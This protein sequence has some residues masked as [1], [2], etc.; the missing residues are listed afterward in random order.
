M[1]VASRSAIHCVGHEG[2]GVGDHQRHAAPER[3]ADGIAGFRVIGGKLPDQQRSLFAIKTVKALG[4]AY[5]AV[6]GRQWKLLTHAVYC[7]VH[8]H[9]SP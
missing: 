7:A 2:F 5:K 6:A 3:R 1:S 9:S 4:Q 8:K